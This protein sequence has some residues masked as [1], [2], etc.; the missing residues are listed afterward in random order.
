MANTKYTKRQLVMALLCFILLVIIIA[1][2]STR[3]QSFRDETTSTNL[4][5]QNQIQQPFQ[6]KLYY[7]PARKKTASALTSY[8]SDQGYQVTMQPAATLISLQS[9]KSLPS[10][11]FYDHYEFGKAMAIKKSI[12]AEI[13]YPVNA[14]KFKDSIHS[15]TMTI[16]LSAAEKESSATQLL[17]VSDPQ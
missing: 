17:P 1:I 4:L 8:L 12:E 6:V 2:V 7:F 10:H 3:G 14:Y 13:G 16:V 9:S 15:G 11:I 5:E